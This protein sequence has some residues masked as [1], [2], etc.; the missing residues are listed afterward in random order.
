M[1]VVDKY[2]E[3]SPSWADL[4]TTDAELAKRF[5]IDLFGWDSSDQ[6]AG[7]GVYTMYSKNGEALVG[8]FQMP[9][10]MEAT[11]S[12]WSIYF[13]TYDIEAAQERVISNGG[14]VIGPTM[15]VLDA[16]KMATCQDPQGATFHFWQPLEHKGAG[17]MNEAGALVWFE[18]IT[19]DPAAAA[20]FYK[21]V[22]LLD[23]RTVTMPHGV[24]Y[25][26]LGEQD[27]G[28]LPKSSAIGEDIPNC[29]EVYFGCDDLDDKIKS[30]KQAGGEVV[31]PVMS[32][33]EPGYMAIMKDPTGAYFALHT[34]KQHY[35]Q[36]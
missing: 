5:Y 12:F 27:A 32:L 9:A 14:K 2:T 21:K 33:G 25:T 6:P 3:G 13:T 11:H 18:L 24:E 36:K 7:D 35:G 4:C 20:N 29:W 23:S 28:I 8:S 1:P 26:L 19:D 30:I 34:P 16:G 22:L 31:V 10:E 15:D 17:I